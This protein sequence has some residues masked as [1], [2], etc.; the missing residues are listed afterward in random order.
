MIHD[1]LPLTRP[2]PQLTGQT[3]F[4]HPT[5]RL[6]GGAVVVVQA[7]EHLVAGPQQPAHGVDLLLGGGGGD[8]FPVGE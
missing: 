5:G 7:G 6:D 2:S 1:A 8:A 3:D 4:W